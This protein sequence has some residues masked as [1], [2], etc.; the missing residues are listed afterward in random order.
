MLVGPDG[1]AGHQRDGSRGRTTATAGRG[2]G[3]TRQRGRVGAGEF[4]F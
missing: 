1:Q 2:R 3:G 4:L